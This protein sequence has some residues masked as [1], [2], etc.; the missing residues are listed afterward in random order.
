MR[1]REIEICEGIKQPR[2]LKAKYEEVGRDWEDM[3]NGLK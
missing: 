3:R 2:I 1:N